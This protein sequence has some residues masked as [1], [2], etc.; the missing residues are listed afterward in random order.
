[1][2]REFWVN[3]FN[4]EGVLTRENYAREGIFKLKLLSFDFRNRPLCET[5]QAA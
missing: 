1:M 5:I 3:L 2:R 4:S